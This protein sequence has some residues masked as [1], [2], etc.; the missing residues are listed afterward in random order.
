MH[1]HTLALTHALNPSPLL[2]SSLSTLITPLLTSLITP[3]L[4]PL[5]GPLLIL[6]QVCSLFHRWTPHSPL[7]TP[8]LT[9]LLDLLTILLSL[10][11]SHREH[12]GVRMSAA[13]LH[14]WCV[15]NAFFCSWINTPY[16][17][18]KQCNVCMYFL[19]L[20]MRQSAPAALVGEKVIENSTKTTMSA[21]ICRFYPQP[22]PTKHVSHSRTSQICKGTSPV[23]FKHEKMSARHVLSPKQTDVWAESY[24]AHLQ[25]LLN[26]VYIKFLQT[27]ESQ[28][29]STTF[30]IT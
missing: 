25:T 12:S 4:A 22:V 26:P 6:L 28:K 18:F 11:S 3:L 16:I 29:P 23:S 21:L 27:N 20:C 14:C 15:E 13:H 1:A 5:L 10:L 7:I 24:G 2:L 8:F 19:F 30:T 9:P 17:C